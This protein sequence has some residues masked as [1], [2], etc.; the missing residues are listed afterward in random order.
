MAVVPASVRRTGAG[1]TGVT[2]NESVMK[3]TGSTASMTHMATLRRP[4]RNT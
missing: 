2:A 1:S 4:S 3:I